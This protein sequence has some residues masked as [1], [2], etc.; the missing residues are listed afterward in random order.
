M[1]LLVVRCHVLRSRQGRMQ[2][3]LTLR[4]LL[5]SLAPVPSAVAANAQCPIFPPDLLHNRHIAFS[6]HL[7][8]P[9]ELQCYTE[10]R[11]NAFL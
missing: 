10:D 3:A 4:K 2:H 7:Q 9:P 11:G 1:M 6:K 8:H 5:T